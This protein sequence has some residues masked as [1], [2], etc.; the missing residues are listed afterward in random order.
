MARELKEVEGMSEEKI[1]RLTALIMNNLGHEYNFFLCS[2]SLY[3]E[4]YITGNYHLR[5]C[6]RLV[7]YLVHQKL[8]KLNK[9]E[10]LFYCLWYGVDDGKGMNGEP[11][12]KKGMTLAQKRRVLQDHPPVRL[13]YVPP[14]SLLPD[15]AKSKTRSVGAKR[16]LRV[17]GNMSITSFFEPVAKRTRQ[18]SDESADEK[19]DPPRQTLS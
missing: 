14:G 11:I 9:R 5:S 19:P 7:D 10:A 18:E 4:A 12:V 1:L 15:L 17:E 13:R 3:S 8:D 16:A 6:Q 2:Q